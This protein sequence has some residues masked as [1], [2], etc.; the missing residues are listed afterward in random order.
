MPPVEL[1]L[2]AAPS[3]TGLRADGLARVALAKVVCTGVAT[4]A[5][6]AYLHAVNP[7]LP[8]HY[9]LCPTYALTGW[10]CPGCG[11]LRALHDLTTGDLASAWSM[12]PLAVLVVPYLVWAWI[13]WLRRVVTGRPRQFLAPA[14]VPMTIGVAMV[15]FAVLRNVPAFAFLAPH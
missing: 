9:P 10:Y 12:N 11:S 14:W 3:A 13:A 4:V 15:L 1:T 6:L 8:G 7:N 5:S 2:D